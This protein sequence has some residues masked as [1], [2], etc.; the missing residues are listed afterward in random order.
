MRPDYHH[1]LVNL[2][3][4]VEQGLGGTPGLYAPLASLPPPQI[5]A[6]RRVVL[7]VIDGLG[8][9]YLQTQAACFP[10]WQRDV[11]TSV[12]PS[13][14]APAIT[15]MMTGVAPQQHAIT[16]WFMY[17]RELGTMAT[18]LPFRSRIGTA[19][20]D[21][22]G[23]HIDS[24][25]GGS[26][27]FN[28]LKVPSDYLI[29]RKL[30]DSAYSQ[31]AAGNAQRYGYKRLYPCFAELRRL[32]R[33]EGGQRFIYA[34]WP[35]LDT[36][37]HQHGIAS[38]VVS[39]HWQTVAERLQHLAE[40][41]RSSDTLLIITADH[42]FIDTQP[43][44]VVSLEQHPELRECLVLPPCVEPRAAG[45]YLREGQR[46]RFERY[47][48]QHLEPQFELHAVDDLIA[49]GWFG[50]GTP[51]PLLAQR[52]GDYLLIGRDRH[53]L[54]ER[55]PGDDEWKMIGV[56]GGLSSAEMRVP[57]LVVECG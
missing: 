46:S 53:V 4:S 41:L 35:T 5:A 48:A 6:A 42:G 22:L 10:D 43:E 55:L 34:Y 33:A 49:A 25:M 44:A 14:T 18:I 38:P 1:S 29:G 7:L 52:L 11:L 16:G 45:C 17:L 26:S 36:L 8:Y 20:L 50:L 9:E 54:T 12:F 24:V 32:A 3:A 13:S 51:H 57:L 31:W 30:V 27:I 28:R 56:H 39:R 47:I 21:K 40:A 23:V 37:A 15:S 2:L 19:P